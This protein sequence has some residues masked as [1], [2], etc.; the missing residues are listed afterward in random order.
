MLQPDSLTLQLEEGRTVYRAY[1]ASS[2]A[3]VAHS[4]NIKHIKVSGSGQLGLP[5]VSMLTSQVISVPAIVWCSFAE[6]LLH[7]AP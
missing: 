5:L 2:A 6:A 4:V 7:L 3:G 1:H